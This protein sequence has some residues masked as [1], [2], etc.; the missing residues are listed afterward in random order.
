[1]SAMLGWSFESPLSVD[2]FSKAVC[3]LND[4]I[5][6]SEFA[7]S[8]PY[9][10]DVSF[11]KIKTVKLSLSQKSSQFLQVTRLPVQE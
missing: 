6:A 4:S 2:M 1:M 3:K 7:L 9:N 8:Y 11:H 5:R 10:R